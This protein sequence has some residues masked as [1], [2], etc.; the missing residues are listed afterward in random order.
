MIGPRELASKDV[1]LEAE[2]AWKLEG[3]STGSD[4]RASSRCNGRGLEARHDRKWMA[5]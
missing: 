5:Q 3:N 1:V 2:S 4:S